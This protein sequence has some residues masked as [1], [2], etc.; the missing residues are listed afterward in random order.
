MRCFAQS[1]SHSGLACSSSAVKSQTQR[2]AKQSPVTA[3]ITC[4]HHTAAKKHAKPRLRLRQKHSKQRLRY[5]HNSS[6]QSLLSGVFPLLGLFSLDAPDHLQAS[7]R[8]WWASTSQPP[9]PEHQTPIRQETPT[10]AATLVFI[11]PDNKNA[12]IVLTGGKPREL[13]APYCLA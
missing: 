2:P 4:V 3:S 9:H 6:P 8:M 13:R 1:V 11:I 5:R 7:K 10:K 12:V